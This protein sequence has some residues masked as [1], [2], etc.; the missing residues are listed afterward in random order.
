MNCSR[1][2]SSETRKYVKCNTCTID[3]VE[4]CYKRSVLFRVFREP[5]VC[6]M[7]ILA[8]VHCIDSRHFEVSKEECRGC[9]RFMKTA[10]KE[11]SFVFRAFNFIIN[12]AFNA[13]RNTLVSDEEI[14]E[15]RLK[16]RQNMKA[17]HD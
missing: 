8:W 16:A 6:G 17:Y 7:R 11:R 1:N 12:P 15:A 2:K 3:L 14:A 4:L 10:L 13:F 9:I 5:L